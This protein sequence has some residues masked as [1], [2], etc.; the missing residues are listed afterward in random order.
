VLQ[1]LMAV[2]SKTSSFNKGVISADARNRCHSLLFRAT[3]G[4]FTFFVAG[5]QFCLARRA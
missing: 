1:I 4:C 3:G 5:P 2:S